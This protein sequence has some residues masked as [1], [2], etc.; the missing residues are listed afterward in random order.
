VHDRSWVIQ[1]IFKYFERGSKSSTPWFC[2]AGFQD[3]HEPFVFPEPWSSLAGETD[4]HLYPRYRVCEVDDR[5]DI[6]RRIDARDFGPVDDGHGVPATFGEPERLPVKRESLQVTAGVV[7][8]LDDR[9]GAIFRSLEST[10]QM[11]NTIV[12]YTTDHREMRDQ[13]MHRL[14]RLQP[15]GSLP[16]FRRPVSL[17]A[18]FGH[19]SQRP[20]PPPRPLA[21]LAPFSPMQS[22]IP[23]DTLPVL[24]AAVVGLGRIGFSFHAPVLAAHAGFELAATVDPEPTR[25]TEARE[26]WQVNAF[27]DLTTLLEND[28]PD[29]VVIASPTP[30]HRDQAVQA[31]RAGCHVVCDKPVATSL[32]DFDVMAAAAKESG[33]HLIAYQPARFHPSISALKSILRRG[34]IGK[35]HTLV[36]NRCNFSRRNDWQAL[37]RHGGGMLNNYGS[38][39][40]DEILSLLGTPDFVSVH[41]ITRRLASL[42]DADDHV[43]AVLHT[44]DGVLI[45]LTISQ[46]NP[47]EDVS[48]QVHG[49]YGSAVWHETERYWQVR[50]F[51]PIKHPPPKLQSGLAAGDRSYQT[52]SLTWNEIRIAAADFPPIDYYGAVHAALTTTA[53]PP[54]NVAES[55]KLLELIARCRASA[56]AG[57]PR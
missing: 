32:V 35:V 44:T 50:S 19:G 46:A 15:D 43:K 47:I 7:N 28:A 34:T 21:N 4:L 25:R 26:A 9:I 57:H 55:R 23:P 42:G 53:A 2:L 30:F 3:L 33:R 6:Y 45:D 12:I 13:P 24:R 17:N 37:I 22:S 27:P 52:E 5:P 40:L 11:E 29:L 48:W 8:V 49:P 14:V 36:R 18:L 51:D 31:L 1:V 56:D 54:V 20:Q 41:C 38:H 10:G 16:R 39:C